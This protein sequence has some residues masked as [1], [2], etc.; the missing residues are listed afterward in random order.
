MAPPRSASAGS[1][2]ACSR[3]LSLRAIPS[4]LAAQ[5]LPPA[6]TTNNDG[7][8]KRL[9]KYR[10]D[11]G[12]RSF[13]FEIIADLLGGPSVYDRGQGIPRGLFYS[14]H[15]SRVFTQALSLTLPHPPV[16]YHLT[17]P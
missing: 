6:T 5:F 8:G 13:G 17:I 10:Q 7:A 15:T 14:A 1:K 11:R 9:M 16:P 2:R 4:K 3:E 12:I